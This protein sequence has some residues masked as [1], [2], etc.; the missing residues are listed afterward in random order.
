MGRSRTPVWQIGRVY[1]INGEYWQ[2]IRTETK[3]QEEIVT[4]KSGNKIMKKKQQYRYNKGDG[5]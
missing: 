1:K 3:L 4:F 2:V 5:W